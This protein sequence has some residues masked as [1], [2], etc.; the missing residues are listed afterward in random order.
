VLGTGI[1]CK[2]TT[3]G[4]PADERGGQAALVAI[5]LPHV[6]RGLTSQ[7]RSLV[8]SMTGMPPRAVLLNAS[9]T[10]SGPPLA[11]GAGII[12]TAEDPEL[13]RYAALLPQPFIHW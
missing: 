11:L 2:A 12:W 1:R 9:H 6:G 3:C 8:E 5:D 7:V 4:G 13:V 10:H